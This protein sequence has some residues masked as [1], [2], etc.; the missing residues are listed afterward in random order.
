MNRRA[1]SSFRGFTL[2]EIIVVVLVFSVMA[3]MAYGGLRSVL[4]T[5]AG[6]EAAMTRTADLQRAYMRLRNDFQNL[7]DRPARDE[8]GDAQAPLSIDRD[9]QLRLIRGGQRNPLGTS[10]SSLE[11]IQY[12]FKDRALHRS[13]WRAIDLPQKSEPVELV[14][15]NNIEEVRWRFLDTGREW[16]EQWPADARNRAAGTSSA[17]DPPPLAVEVTL[18]TKDWGETR[19][20]F[21]T[22][23]AGLVQG[24]AGGDDDESGGGAF[25]SGGALL[26]TEG[27]LPASALGTGTAPRAPAS[28]KPG[29]DRDTHEEPSPAPEPEL[30]PEPEIPSAEEIP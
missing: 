15:L 29:E 10:R 3:V 23:Q 28:E 20:L 17:T 19:F 7:R 12:T 1:P 2:L 24:D 26:T 27:L 4:R 14:L 22:P 6:I 30:P 18:V 25:E 8:Y 21:R 5:R 11:R 13:T 16:R 9:G